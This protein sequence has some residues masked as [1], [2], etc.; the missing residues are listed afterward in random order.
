MRIILIGQ[1]IGAALIGLVV[2]AVWYFNPS[3]LTF[4][5]IF[6]P[7]IDL[8]I[9]A[10]AYGL[11]RRG[12]FYTAT[13]FYIVTTILL[14]TSGIYLVGGAQGPMAYFF[15]WFILAA[16]ML[17]DV[18]AAFEI[19]ALVTVIYLVFALGELGGW[20]VPPMEVYRQ[21]ADYIFPAFALLLFWLVALLTRL[22]SGS[23]QSALDKTRRLAAELSTHREELEAQVA[24][25]TADLERRA[26]QLQVAA[27]VARDAT[28]VLDVEALMRTTVERIGERFGFYH[29]GLF[30]LDE[31]G[32]Y[33][34]LRAASSEGG[35]R[36]L[37]R[38]HKLKVGEEGIV[39]YVAGTGKP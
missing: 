38:G 20:L 15:V 26:V 2:I 22:F 23:L 31:A 39:G 25:R 12:R 34:V 18:R 7:W 13:Y 17:I 8:P 33:A 24:Q 11:A 28:G 36:M 4:I 27:E 3:P 29:V 37:A 5:T 21:V 6:P 35:Q 32:E 30:L 16:G 9:C 10:L 19:A 14:V 1:A